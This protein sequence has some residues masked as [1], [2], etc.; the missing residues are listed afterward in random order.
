MFS[1]VVFMLALC[2]P[3]YA[4]AGASGEHPIAGV[5][6]LLQ[7]LKIQSTEEGEAEKASFQKFTYWC[8]TSEKTLIKAIK[9]AKK[10]IA[11]LTDKIDG[12]TAD[13]GALGE[14]IKALGADIKEMETAAEKA[15]GVRDD[16]KTL[17]DDEQKNFED[18]ISAV[19]EAIDI[20]KDSKGSLIQADSAQMHTIQKV[21]VLAE[22]MGKP[23]AKTYTFK[24]GAI[25]ETF[26]G[27][28][29]QFEADKLDSTSAE[30]NKAN[31]YN[32]AKQARD[33]SLDTAK[34]SKKEKEDIKG[35]KESEKANSETA[36]SETEG[37][38]SGDTATLEQ[39]DKECKTVTGEW[40]ERSAIREGE[41]KAV[42]MAIK[43]LAKVGNV[44]NPDEHKAPGKGALLGV[45]TTVGQDTSEYDA[46]EDIPATGP[47]GLLKAIATVQQDTSDYRAEIAPM[48]S[49]ISFLQLE[50]PKTK[51]VN[52][53]KRTASAIHS[54]KLLKLARAIS[55]YGGP[56]DKIKGM[57]QKMIFQLMA[58]QKDEDEHK[59]WCDGET[60]K[61]EESQED[62]D[63]KVKMYKKKIAE[64]DSAIKKLIKQ[65]TENNDKS[66]EMQAY[67]EQETAL[68]EE[69]H[70]ECK[71]TIKDSQDAQAAVEQATQVL[72][73]FYKESGMIAKEPWEFVQVSSRRGVDLPDSPDTWDSSYTGASDPENGAD[74]V[75]AILDGCHEKFSKMEADAKV[76]DETD[77]KNYDKDMQAKKIELAETEQ[78]TKMKTN[79]QHSMQE[80]MEGE[81]AQ[82]KHVS[83][84]LDAVTTYLKDLQ[85]ACGEGDSSYEDR[86]KGRSDEITALRKAQTILEDAFRAKA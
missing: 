69:N 20:L 16:E 41:I 58:E 2:A 76:T 85:P 7:K 29:A 13:I 48:N 26:K 4:L 77:Q 60:E 9:T 35:D 21:Q 67:M 71:A 15:K 59:N 3:Q 8:K 70:A 19:G 10:D 75:L 32:L 36:L 24:S 50:D 34:D 79:K 82:L 31:A 86:K 68:R 39:T 5:I 66:S 63:E 45:E 37:S 17:Y 57:I 40:E 53:L 44:R 11:S 14:D 28:K 74:G 52:L 43:I 65:I 64:L 51:A 55:S 33:K 6:S 22:A 27:M 78:D 42:S 49:G 12:L 73:D 80:K 25:I 72:K 46:M 47:I 62:K 18:T 30:T 23:A 83:G 56:F 38:L 81:Q 54:K 84:E 1:T 61:S